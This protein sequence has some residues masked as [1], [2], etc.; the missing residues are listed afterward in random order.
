[1]AEHKVFTLDIDIRFRD[2]D[3]RGHV[4]NA[5]YFTYCEH[6]RLRFYNVELQQN[7]LSEINIILAHTSCDFIKPVTLS[8][9]IELQIRVKEIGT[10]SFT[11][12]YHLVDRLDTSVVYARA[13]SVL[14][15][16]DYE[17]NISRPVP[18]ELKAKLSEYLEA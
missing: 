9:Q 10:K 5:V 17:K 1:M 15:F 4:N 13:E 18:D 7:K 2:I 6:G 16:F 14:V 3:G 11:L 12:V 8:D